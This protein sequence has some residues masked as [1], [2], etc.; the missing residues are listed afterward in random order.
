MLTLRN[1]SIYLRT[2]VLK[3]PIKRIFIFFFAATPDHTLDFSE[4]KA[5]SPQRC[6]IAKDSWRS[7]PLPKE[8]TAAERLRGRAPR[9]PSLKDSNDYDESKQE[10]C[11]SACG[12]AGEFLLEGKE[13]REVK[14]G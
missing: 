8:L 12:E 14:S 13:N 4:A 10:T 7:G 1:C 3:Q 5:S 2:I 6:R 11:E 9:H